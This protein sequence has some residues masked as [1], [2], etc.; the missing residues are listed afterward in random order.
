MNNIITICPKCGK[1]FLNNTKRKFC[2]RHCANSHIQT[3]EQNL[4]RSNK[5]KIKNNVN[6]NIIKYNNK[7]NFCII[8]GKILDYKRRNR[9]TCLNRECYKK[10]QSQI[11]RQWLRT[12]GTKH[13][14]KI[15]HYIIYKTTCLID[16][17][18]YIGVHK[19]DDLKEDTY[20]GNGIILRKKIKKYGKENFKRITLFEFNN[21]NDAFNKENEV[22]ILYINDKQCLNIGPGGIGGSHFAGK[23]HTEKTKQKLHE[24]HINKKHNNITKQKLKC[25]WHKNH[26]NKICP[27]CGKNISVCNYSKHIKKHKIGRAHV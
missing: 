1:E 5:L 13:I 18:Y 20:L 7:P 6:N 25:N 4:Q 16:N 24:I 11:Q 19:I 8:C 26:P 9:K 21:S 23:H 14:N 12:N 17:T 2:S 10:Y 3:K 22:I 27:F 15:G